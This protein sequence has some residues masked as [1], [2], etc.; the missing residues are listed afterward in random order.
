MIVTI[1][2]PSGAGKSSISRRLAETLG[3]KFLDTGAMYRSVAWKGLKLGIQLDDQE[4][5]E[6]VAHQLQIKIQSEAVFVDG[7]D[8]S[9][10][11]RSTEVTQATRFAA[12]N[13]GVRQRLIELQREFADNH[14]IVTEGRDQGTVVFP[15]APCKIFLTA[16]AEERARRRCNEILARGE[17]VNLAE[18]YEQQKKRDEED[19]NR[20]VGP[21]LKAP[22]AVEVVT[23]G[24]SA[25]QV[26]QQLL[27]IVRRCRHG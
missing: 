21:L 2:G 26:L 18:I 13:I 4:T 8:V 22:D 14:D 7:E 5:L 20:P 3:F 1:D 11:I 9:Q 6:R 25:D 15:D 24:M 27:E 17:P 19:R 10:A 23:D 16:T 12:D